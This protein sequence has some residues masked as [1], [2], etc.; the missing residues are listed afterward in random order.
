MK[1]YSRDLSNFASKTRIV[2]REKGLDV[3]MVSP[4][5]GT[6]SP[7]YKKLNPLGKIPA[8][9]LDGGQVIA[10]SE[11]IN[12]YLEDKFPE[13]PLLPK[14]AEGRARVRA[15]SRLNDLYLDP[16]LRA[17]LPQLFGKKLEDAFVQEKIAEI[18][19]RLDQ[20]EVMIGSPWAAGDAFTMA[21]AALTPTIFFMVSILPQFGAQSPLE[22]RP[23]LAAWWRQVQERPST[24]GTLGEQQAALAAMMKK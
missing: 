10:E 19:N 16:P 13:K 14:D 22:G 5:G 24:K 9:Q 21:D 1:L 4:P 3:E 23:K 2:I 20:L 7:E 12:E 8:L 15:F 11:I 18:G 17:L 6:S